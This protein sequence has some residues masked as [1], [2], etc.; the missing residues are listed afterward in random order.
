[1]P[2]LQEGESRMIDAALII[3][4]LALIVLVTAF[5]VRIV[6]A[7]SSRKQSRERP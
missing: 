7:L 6:E 2:A 3:A 5:I 1:M 4:A